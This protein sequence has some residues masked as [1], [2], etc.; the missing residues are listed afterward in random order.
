MYHE[1]I[2]GL[3]H[4]DARDTSEAPALN[5]AQL[6]HFTTYGYVAGIRVLDEDQVSASGGARAALSPNDAC[7]RPTQGLAGELAAA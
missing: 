1:P 3:L 7:N 5:E 2:G 6:E 4:A